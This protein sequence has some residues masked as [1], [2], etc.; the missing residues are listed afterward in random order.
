MA[1]NSSNGVFVGAQI[2]IDNPDE[3]IILGLDAKIKIYA[4]EAKSVLLIPVV[5]LNADKNG[6]YV[7]VIEDGIAVRKDIVTGISNVE[8][9]FVGNFGFR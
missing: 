6:D 2:R 8:F 3:N 5:A 1:Q 4:Q 7:Y 9:T